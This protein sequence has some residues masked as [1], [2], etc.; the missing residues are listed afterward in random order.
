MKLDLC[1]P[2]RKYLKGD[3]VLKGHGHGHGELDALCCCIER[4]KNLG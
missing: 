3:T 2:G 4:A 1:S